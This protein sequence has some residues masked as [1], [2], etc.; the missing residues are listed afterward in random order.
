MIYLVI[1]SIYFFVI[2][3]HLLLVRISDY[4]ATTWPVVAAPSVP[5]PDHPLFF[6][7]LSMHTLQQLFDKEWK[8]IKFIPI[9]LLL[10]I[11]HRR[12]CM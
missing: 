8:E 5:D 2:F 1:W 7:Y 3:F 12:E 9:L 6:F 11:P 10:Y 4:H